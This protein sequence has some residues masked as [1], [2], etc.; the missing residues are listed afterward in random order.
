MR[1]P[2]AGGGTWRARGARTA[3]ATAASDNAQRNRPTRADFRLCAR[4]AG[5]RGCVGSTARGRPADRASRPPR[6][7]APAREPRHRRGGVRGARQRARPPTARAR[8]VKAARPAHARGSARAAGASETRAARPAQVQRRVTCR[9]Q[10]A[11]GQPEPRHGGGGAAA[12]GSEAARARA[13]PTRFVS[14]SRG[15]TRRHWAAAD[16]ARPLPP[17]S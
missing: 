6:R 1:R 3:S 16:E 9:A 12:C 13:P 14:A 2:G 7:F 10:A 15:L 17:I 11:G 5:K 4:S 8:H